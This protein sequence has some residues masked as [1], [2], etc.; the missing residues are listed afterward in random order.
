MQCADIILLVVLVSCVTCKGICCTFNPCTAGITSICLGNH[1]LTPAIYGKGHRIATLE[2]TL[3][4]VAFLLPEG[5]YAAVNYLH[6]CT[7]Y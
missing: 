6:L 4:A 5:K 2:K 3:R 1:L 7:L